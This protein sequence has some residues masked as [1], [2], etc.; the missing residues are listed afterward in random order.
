MPKGIADLLRRN[1]KI[2]PDQT[3]KLVPMAYATSGGEVHVG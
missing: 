1:G 2:L 3:S